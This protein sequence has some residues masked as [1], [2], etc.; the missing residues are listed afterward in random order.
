MQSSC[1]IGLPCSL[2][3]LVQKRIHEKKKMDKVMS[4]YFRLSTKRFI[5]FVANLL[6]SSSLIRIFIKTD[7]R[8]IKLIYV[9]GFN[10][11]KFI[12]FLHRPEKHENLRH[13]LPPPA[14]ATDF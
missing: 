12:F 3:K 10:V 7:L 9:G 1:Y 5:Q 13:Q 6:E 14:L 11:T 8:M 4:Y 2:N